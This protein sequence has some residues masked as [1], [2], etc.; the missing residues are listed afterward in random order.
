MVGC[1]SEVKVECVDSAGIISTDRSSLHG[2]D[3]KPPTIRFL[4]ADNETVSTAE[5]SS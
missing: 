5:Q 1:K 4:S 3:P 2:T